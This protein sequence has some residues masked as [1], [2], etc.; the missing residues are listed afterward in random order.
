MHSLTS[1][2]T[3]TA[4]SLCTH[5]PSPHLH[6]INPPHPPGPQG[7]SSPPRW[8]PPPP[9]SPV[10]TPPTRRAPRWRL[11]PLGGPPRA[12]GA[13]PSPPRVLVVGSVRTPR[14]ADAAA[15]GARGAPS[16][17]MPLVGRV[18]RTVRVWHPM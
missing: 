7:A 8:A 16:A 3:P 18:L 5:P 17:L 6:R 12:S 9:T 10:S 4:Q 15:G 14:V 2:F 11:R 1:L 13:V